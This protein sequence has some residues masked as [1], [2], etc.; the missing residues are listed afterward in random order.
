MRMYDGVGADGGEAYPPPLLA[1]AE[2]LSS[3]LPRHLTAPRPRPVHALPSPLQ[4][5]VPAQYAFVI[6]TKNPSNNDEE[7]VFCEMVRGLGAGDWEE[8]GGGQ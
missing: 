1:P 2:A 3:S 8:G 5:V 6:H 7:E 4:R